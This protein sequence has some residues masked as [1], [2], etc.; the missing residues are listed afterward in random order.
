MLRQRLLAH[1]AL[2]YPDVDADAVAGSLL[3]RQP[4]LMPKY[5]VS[6][7]DA[8]RASGYSQYPGNIR[9]AAIATIS[10]PNAPPT[11]RIK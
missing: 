11:A 3:D 10:P 6:R 2:I 9:G 7:H 4:V 8:A 1:I 5:S